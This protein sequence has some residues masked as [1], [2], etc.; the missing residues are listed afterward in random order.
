MDEKKELENI[1]KD[2]S[3]NFDNNTVMFLLYLMFKANLVTRQNMSHIIKIIKETKPDLDV[4]EF[5]IKE[6]NKL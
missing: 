2:K 4:N 1:H 6:I 5:I 3:F